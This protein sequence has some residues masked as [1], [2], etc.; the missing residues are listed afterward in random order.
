MNTTTLA[1]GEYKVIAEGNK[2]TIEK[3][4]KVVAEVP[5]TLKTLSNKAPQTAATVDHG[6]LTEILASGKTE[7]IE[8]SSS[9]N[10]GN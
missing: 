2:A 8:F 4:G 10:S 3:G 5:C 7:A 1:P 9:Q 6:S